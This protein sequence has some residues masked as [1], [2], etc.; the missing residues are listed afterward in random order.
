M[1]RLAA[2]ALLLAPLAACSGAKDHQ[3]FV[4][5]QRAAAA[6]YRLE[7]L[8]AERLLVVHSPAGEPDGVELA[9]LRSVFLR[10]QEASDSVDGKA[11]YFWDFGGRERVVSAP[12]FATEPGTVIAILAKEL[13][14][15]DQAAATRMA[16]A[17]Q[18]NEGRHCMV[19]VSAEYLMETRTQKEGTCRP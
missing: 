3:A 17:F 14:G 1:T 13:A 19:W 4:A 5:Q 2:A 8:A 16:T 6:G 15:F 11:R 18:R 10:R 9:A 7:H 12:Y